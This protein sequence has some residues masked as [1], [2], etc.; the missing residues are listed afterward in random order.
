MN[1]YQKPAIL[2]YKGKY[3]DNWFSNMKE[4]LF[5]VDI[6]SYQTVEHFYQA[7]KANNML[8]HII[9]SKAETPYEA[10]KLGNKVQQP[11]QDFIGKKNPRNGVKFKDIQEVKLYVM[12]FALECKFA[13]PEWRQQLLDT[14]DE[15]IIEWNNWN[16]KFWGVSIKDCKGKNHLGRLLMEIREEI[17][18]NNN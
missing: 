13:I 4:S 1:T 5:V 14:K 3:I 11:F 12:R 15:E 8:E 9:I 2:R 16:D 17:K 10:K 18:A 7:Y 6:I